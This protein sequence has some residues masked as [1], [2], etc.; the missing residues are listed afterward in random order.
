MIRPRV[1]EE[2][3]SPINGKLTVVKDLAWGIHIKAGGLTQSGGIAKTVSKTAIKKVKKMGLRV[4]SALV[5]G[6]GGGS[7]A[8]LIRKYWRDAKITGVDIDPLMVELGKK[9]LGLKGKGVRVVIEDAYDFV[10]KLSNDSPNKY[11]LI[12]VDLYIG[13]KFPKKFEKKS[14]LEGVKKLLKRGGVVVFNRLYYGE[15][16]IE[17]VKFGQMLEK[18]FKNVKVVLPEANSVFLCTT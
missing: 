7:A 9:Y 13:D 1:L 15:K 6:L 12:F 4:D 17:A 8:V 14:F 10:A 18:E 11:D 16:R 2:V 5:L 3:H